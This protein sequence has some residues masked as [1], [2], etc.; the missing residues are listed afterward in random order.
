M[1]KPSF[2]VFFGLLFSLLLL[3]HFSASARLILPSQDEQGVKAIDVTN[4]RSN[5]ELNYDVQPVESDE[6]D[7]ED[8][9]CSERRMITEAHLD[10]IYTQHHKPAYK[11]KP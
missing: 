4:A 11:H 10:Y 6:C 5:T 2:H 1:K 8:V 3:F 9:E 7:N